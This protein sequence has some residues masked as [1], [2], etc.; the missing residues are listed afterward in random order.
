[1]KKNKKSFFLSICLLFSCTL[2]ACKT[3][4]QPTSSVISISANKLV[5]DSSNAKYDLYDNFS[6]DD[7]S[8]KLVKYVDNIEVS[9]KTIDSK[10]YILSYEDGTTLN[11]GDTLTKLGDVTIN[12]RL[13]TKDPTYALLN[14]SFTIN[15]SD[16]NDLKQQLILTKPSKTE[17]AVAESFEYATLTATYLKTYKDANGS[18][19]TKQYNLTYS[20]LDITIDNKNAKYYAFSK[21]E[22]DI[23]VNVSY[24]CPNNEVIS[25]YFLVSCTK[26]N[27]YDS[28][29]MSVTFT[30]SSVSSSDKGYYTPEEVETNSVADYAKL[31][32][33]KWMYTPS[34]GNVNFLV[35]PLIL[36]GDNV[37]DVKIA[38]NLELIDQA[39]NGDNCTFESLKTYYA[40]SS[41][42]QLNINSVL[43]KTLNVTDD[44]KDYPNYSKYKNINKNSDDS[45][46]TSLVTD[47][48]NWAI[49][50][51][52]HEASYFDYNKDGCIDGIWFIYMGRQQDSSTTLYWA[53]TSST[54]QTGSVKNPVTNIYGWCGM[55]FLTQ[56][57]ENENVDTHTIIHET[58]HMLGLSDYYSYAYSGYSP[59]GTIDMMDHNVG[60]QNS[61]SKLLLGWVKPYIVY[62]NNVTISLQSCQFKNSLIVFS[63]DDKKYTKTSNNKVKFNIFDEYMILD[64]YTPTNLNLP[65]KYTIYDA[66]TLSSSGGRLYHVDSR[67]AYLGTN[68]GNY[69]LFNDPDD[70]YTFTGSVRRFITN[71]ESGSRAETSFGFPVTYNHFDEI[72]WISADGRLLNQY[73]K[74]SNFPFPGTTINYQPANEYSLFNIGQ[75]QV[76]SFSF[77]EFENQFNATISRYDGSTRFFNNQKKCSFSFKINSFDKIS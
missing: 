49:S 72:R 74:T 58:G 18:E 22:N 61:Y 41:Y 20:D 67:L 27:E 57:K 13:N 65:I 6:I 43:T 30:N 33:E 36:P 38:D 8:V 60:D 28:K 21:L 37:S 53:F 2:S 51:S 23:R 54:S 44:L 10:S 75:N 31:S 62:G 42:N 34:I 40:K 35:V 9:A 5:V 45:L 15:V 50:N 1:M 55:D 59:L 68:D 24:T 32:S 70:I 46:I 56:D 73:E 11:D 12:V 19:K 14:T 63:Y 29:M 16:I 76:S 4:D 17:Y 25:A 69:Y 48:S 39:F 7:I 47:A 64:Y 3:N 66:A 77:E 52:G 71:S 26:D